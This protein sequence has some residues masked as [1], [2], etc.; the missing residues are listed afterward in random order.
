MPSHGII[1]HSS[2]WWTSGLIAGWQK[3]SPHYVVI[4]CSSLSRIDLFDQ[5]RGDAK[6]H[7]GCDKTRLHKNL[8]KKIID[9]EAGEKEPRKQSNRNKPKW[10]Q[11]GTFLCSGDVDPD[12]SMAVAQAPGCHLS[13]AVGITAG[14]STAFLSLEERCKHP[15]IPVQ[16]YQGK[17][18]QIRKDLQLL[19]SYQQLQ[20]PSLCLF[21]VTQ[22]NKN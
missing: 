8:I 21:Q 11:D 13:S 20:P 22:I 1:L 6:I 4:K 15:P 14:A 5:E 19:H 16:P 3:T 17:S 18:L 9:W 12:L 10:V 2:D 7:R